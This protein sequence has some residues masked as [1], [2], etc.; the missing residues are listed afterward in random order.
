MQ[1]S[2]SRGFQAEDSQ[3]KNPGAEACHVCLRKKEATC[4]M[5][6]GES[7]GR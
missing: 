7:S 4:G 6:K 5:S 2:W 3:C 1:I